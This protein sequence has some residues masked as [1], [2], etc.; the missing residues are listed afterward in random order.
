MINKKQNFK[1]NQKKYLKVIFINRYLFIV[2]LGYF[3]D[4]YI[5]IT[6]IGL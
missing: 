6:Y 2:N 1:I 3:D 4:M 5:H